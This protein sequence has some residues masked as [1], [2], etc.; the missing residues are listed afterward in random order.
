MQEDVRRILKVAAPFAGVALGWYLFLPNFKYMQLSGGEYKSQFLLDLQKAEILVKSIH[1]R[2]TT[3]EEVRERAATWYKC[4]ISALQ[5]WNS[6]T[7][8]DPRYGVIGSY[9]HVAATCGP[10]PRDDS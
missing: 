2:L 6:W 8:A 3:A 5:E 9:E 4:E 7:S 10:D 1:Y